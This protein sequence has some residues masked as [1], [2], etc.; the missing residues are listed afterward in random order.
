MLAAAAGGAE[1]ADLAGLAEEMRRRCAQPDTDGDDG[2]F[3]DRWLRLDRTLH[4]AGRVEGDLTP[5]CTAA[6]DAVLDAFSKK[7]GPEDTRTEGQRHHDGLEEACRQL[8]ASGCVPDRAGQP[9]LIQLHMTLDQLRGLDGAAHAEAAW[10]ARGPAAAPGSDCDATIV[11]VVSGHVDPAVLDQLTAALLSHDPARLGESAPPARYGPGSGYGGRSGFGAGSGFDLPSMP[12]PQPPH[13]QRSPYGPQSPKA[14]AVRRL[15]LR[16]AADLLSGPAGLAA[17]LRT[18]LPDSTAAGSISLPL[19]VGRAAKT[20]PDHLR[21]AVIARDRCC[22]FP[23]CRQ[24]P[25]A[26]QAHHVKPRSQGGTT[27]LNNLILL[28]AFHHLTA[29]HRWGWHLT[30]HPDGT[31]TAVSPDQQ[32]TLNS[33]GPPA[34]A[35]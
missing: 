22:R 21:R 16:H 3:A 25:A 35:A 11:P 10:A 4:D 12:E 31:V 1:L 28:C 17:F 19:D 32:R 13:G 15:I 24:R 9:T 14:A 2:G 26:C 5:Q 33:H 29:I 23:G 20:I 30:L 8:I 27:S 34:R 7:T 6:L 18:G